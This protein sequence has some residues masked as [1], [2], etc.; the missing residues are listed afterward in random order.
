MTRPVRTRQRRK[1]RPVPSPLIGSFLLE[2]ITTGMYG[3]R[4]NAIREYVQNSFDGI[5]QAIASK[6]LRAGA[7]RVSLTISSDRKD[8]II[9][10]NGMGLPHRIA[11]NT[12]TAVGASRKE[13]ARQAGFRGIGRLAGIAFA[14]TL[15]FR[16]KAAG[17][18]LETVVEFDCEALRRGMLDAGRKPAADLITDCTTFEQ[19]PTSQPAD[20]YFEVSLLGMRNAPAEAT[21]PL[22][23]GTFLSQVAPVDFHPDFMA[24][25][26]RIL[27]EAD[28]AETPFVEES[29]DPVDLLD[30]GDDLE[31][32]ADWSV[33]QDD[34]QTM[35]ERVPMPHVGIVVRSGDP[36]TEHVIHKPYRSRLGVNDTDDVPLDD[37]SV[38]AGRT[39]AWWGW[40]GHKSKPGEYQDEAVGGIRFR[41]RN[42]QI[43][44]SDLIASV[45]TTNQVRDPFARWSRWFM[46]EIH[47]DPRAVVPNA[48]R[49]NFEE[50]PRWLA[51]REE[52]SAICEELTAEARRVSRE[53]RTSIEVIDQKAT[54]LREDYLAVVTAKNSV[55]IKR[56][57]S[58]PTE[59]NCIRT[60]KRLRMAPHLPSSFG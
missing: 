57:K 32:K 11:V 46:G 23:L 8:L 39:G 38:H 12:L 42:I 41:L 40:I 28:E 45:P 43:D 17:D 33:L 15:R 37:V 1:G 58:S 22:Q 20:H 10:D 29:Y 49:D 60:S 48:R 52:V 34:A 47:V 53:Y 2:S 19:N 25:R 24:F 14:T 54:K 18:E 3:E 27:R 4:R 56:G 50:D 35:L 16:T 59:I 6:V 44:G 31:P 51:I 21:D 55:R 36:V 9:L 13:R 5:Q 7:G 30:G 26:E